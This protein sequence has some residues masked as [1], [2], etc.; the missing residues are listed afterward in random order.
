[1]K[2]NF[3]GQTIKWIYTLYEY[4][5]V[6][7]CQY[8]DHAINAPPKKILDAF[9]LGHVEDTSLLKECS[10]RSFFWVPIQVVFSSQQDTNTVLSKEFVFWQLVTGTLFLS[11]WWKKP[12]IVFR[13]VVR[14]KTRE[15]QN[16]CSALPLQYGLESSIAME[17]EPFQEVFSVGPCGDHWYVGVGRKT[18]LLKF[19]GSR[20]KRCT[21]KSS[22]SHGGNSQ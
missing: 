1:M 4:I 8:K 21:G 18:K 7:K 9:F 16:Q 6:I 19:N 2:R 14:K 15:L 5:H 10:Q 11:A 13:R 12:T 17:S 3:G 22:H 20:I